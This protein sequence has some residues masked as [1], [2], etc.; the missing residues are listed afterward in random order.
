MSGYI[1]LECYAQKL[2]EHSFFFLVFYSE[3]IEAEEKGKINRNKDNKCY[4]KAILY[5]ALIVEKTQAIP[6]CPFK[7]K[8]KCFKNLT[9]TLSCSQKML[10]WM[11]TRISSKLNW[12]KKEERERESTRVKEMIMFLAKKLRNTLDN[13]V[14]LLK[15]IIERLIFKK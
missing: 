4:Y 1:F 6:W 12:Y 8:K 11:K 5:P 7:P 9:I 3:Y 2:I 13:R 10:R 14:E 15:I